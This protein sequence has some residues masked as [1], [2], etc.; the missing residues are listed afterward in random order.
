MLEV[1]TILR[2]VLSTRTVAPASDR[3]ERPRW[4]GAILVPSSGGRVVLHARRNSTGHFF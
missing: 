3:V 4:R 2:H 1:T